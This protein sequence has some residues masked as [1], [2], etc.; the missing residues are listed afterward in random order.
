MCGG[1]EGGGGEERLCLPRGPG[2]LCVSFDA[3]R[4]SRAG[5]RS[6]PEARQGGKFVLNIYGFDWPSAICDTAAVTSSRAPRPRTPARVVASGPTTPR[7]CTFGSRIPPATTHVL[8]R[9]ISTDG[10]I[11]RLG[12]YISF[13]RLRLP[14]SD[15]QDCLL[16]TGSPE[17]FQRWKV[18]ADLRYLQLRSST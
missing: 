13:A 17:P 11:W 15:A 18:V 8:S 9:L 1:E 4:L 10:R 16:M 2:G 5:T 14:Y 12:S 3:R 7:A 6:T